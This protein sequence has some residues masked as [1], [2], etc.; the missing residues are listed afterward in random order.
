MAFTESKWGRGTR[1]CAIE[2]VPRSV[3]Y[4]TCL[5]W[6]EEWCVVTLTVW[7]LAGEDIWVQLA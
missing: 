4:V 1:F 7:R 3:L 2:L 5:L 6:G